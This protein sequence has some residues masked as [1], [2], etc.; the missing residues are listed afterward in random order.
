MTKL[1]KI[2]LINFGGIGDEILFLPTILSLK[3]E[4]PNSV[5]TL[6]L[7]PRSCGIADLSDK[8]DRVI[9]VDLKNGNKYIELMKLVFKA[10]FGRYDIVI[11]SGANRMIPILLLMMFVPKRYGYDSGKLSR[12]LLTKA[13][14]LN[15]NQYAA[16][17]YHDLIN[18]LT[19]PQVN[20]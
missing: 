8:I 3:K 19:S 16:M 9:K 14:Q 15:K 12:L 20:L 13:V 18:P 2:L 1:M 6:A 10:W 7:E 11:S 5:I 4:F 17:M